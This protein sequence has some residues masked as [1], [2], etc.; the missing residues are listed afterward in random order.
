MNILNAIKYRCN[1][2]FNGGLS[3][4]P[5]NKKPRVII[6]GHQKSGTT[7][8]ATLIA[9]RASL[10]Y[11]ADIVRSHQHYH[12]WDSLH[13]KEIEL[14]SFCKKYK[15][16]FSKNLLKEPELSFFYNDLTM[17]F[18]TSKFIFVLRNPFDN[19]KSILSRLKINN[20]KELKESTTYRN[21]VAKFPMWKNILGDIDNPIPAL[22]KRWNTLVDIYEANKENIYL[23]KYEDFS[24]NKTNVIDEL[25]DYADVQHVNDINGLVNLQYQKKGSRISNANFFRDEDIILIKSLIIKHSNYYD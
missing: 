6:L 11:T 2:Y 7:A 12:D 21:E 19:I 24:K 13:K 9:K 25:C 8:I 18:P 23:L 16:E 22:C 10:S 14:S 5:N 1:I 20:M 15:Y 17:Q 4:L 3:K